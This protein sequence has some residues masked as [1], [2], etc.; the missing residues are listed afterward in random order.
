MAINRKKFFDNFPK[1]SLDNKGLNASRQQGFDAIFDAW[2]KRGDGLDIGG[3]AYAFAT[4]W[5]ETGARMQPVREGFATT[6]AG[7]VAAVTA[8]CRKK[9]IKNYAARQSNGNSYYGRG[10]VQLTFPDNYKKM[11]KTLGLASELFDKPD[12]VLDPEIGA[13]ILVTGMIGGLFRPAK[14]KI[15][16]Y[17]TANTHNWFDARDMINGDKNVKVWGNPK[18]N[19]QMIADYGKGF[20]AAL[21][22]ASK[23]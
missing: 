22:L 15:T 6:D 13:D 12:E 9:G 18:T 21:V 4:A 14:G 10:Y 19:G 17:F 5:H 20:F 3:L 8:F 7:A 23:P 1:S 16:K 2:D 11:G